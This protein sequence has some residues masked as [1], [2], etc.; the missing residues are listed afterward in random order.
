[1]YAQDGGGFLA[2]STPLY[3]VAFTHTALVCKNYTP[4]FLSIDQLKGR[5]MLLIVD[6]YRCS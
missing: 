5:E 1:M 4:T 6:V 3:V 2:V